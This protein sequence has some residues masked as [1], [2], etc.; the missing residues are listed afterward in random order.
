SVKEGICEKNCEKAILVALSAGASQEEV[1]LSLTELAS[2]AKTAGI[3]VVSQVIQNRSK[4]C[5]ATYIGKGKAE[6]I[7]FLAQN[8]DA[9]LIIFD[10]EITPAA[11]RNLENLIGRKIIDRSLL[12]LDIFAQ[13]AKSNEGKIQVELAQLKYLLPRLQGQGLTLSRL[14]GGVGTRGPGETKLETDKR[15]I[16]SRIREMEHRLDEILKTRSLHRKKQLDGQYPLVALV[17]YTNSGKSTLL[18]SLAQAE[19]LA[20][21]LLF[22]TLDPLTRQV[23]LKDGRKILLSD[24]VGFI[25]RLPHH[26]VAA[27]RST[28][29][30]VV[31]ADLLLHIVDGSAEDISSQAEAV[32][33][34]L[35]DLHVLDKPLL[36]V[37]NKADLI[38]NEVLLKRLSVVFEESVVISA[39]QGQG[40]EELLSKIADILPESRVIK[41]MILPYSAGN[42]LSF[43]HEEGEILEKEYLPEGIRIKVKINAAYG[44]SD[45]E[46]WVKK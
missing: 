16:R 37:I 31:E 38:D 1:E 5:S 34:V 42:I 30:K 6:E 28:L 36:T 10:D 25:R 43:F 39:A 26:L 41:E 22:A 8:L 15:K 27:F 18:N 19:A 40:L 46:D 44:D 33:K 17:G 29:E 3:E 14:G 13:R 21:D 45:W 11:Q 9:D 20:E 4:A 24:T 2:L 12:I 32:I 7:S 35:G 23:V